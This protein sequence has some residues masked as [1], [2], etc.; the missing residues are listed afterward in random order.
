M[1]KFLIR[2]LLYM[3]LTVWVITLIS[4]AV[5]Q[6]PPGDFVTNMVSQMM[7][8]DDADHVAE[9]VERGMSKIK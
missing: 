5:I 8:Q 3:I 2:R 1:R 7:G 9:F 4:F 6:L